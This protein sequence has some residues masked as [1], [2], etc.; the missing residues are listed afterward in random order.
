[1]QP[2]HF[3]NTGS[4]LPEVTQPLGSGK[5]KPT[6]VS[7]RLPPTHP[8]ATQAAEQGGC[9]QLPPSSATTS[10]VHLAGPFPSLSRAG[11]DW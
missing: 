4:D 8:Q 10:S 2:A 5:S 11:K 7:G 6:A 1:M 9:H 3:I